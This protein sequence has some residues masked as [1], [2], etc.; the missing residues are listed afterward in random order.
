[1]SSQVTPFFFNDKSSNNNATYGN[2]NFL[3]K[4]INMVK[5]GKM[6]QPINRNNTI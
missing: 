3:K 6:A 2:N 5:I 1:M 4:K